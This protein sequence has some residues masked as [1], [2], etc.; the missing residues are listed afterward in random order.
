M[1]DPLF[2]SIAALGAAYRNRTLSPV[3][4]TRQA[5]E[6]IA[7]LDAR[8]NSFITVLE[9]R[10]LE[11][12][13]AAEHELAAGRDR[14]PLHGVPIAIKDLMD[15]AGVPTTFAS[16][17]GSPKLPGADAPVIQ[18]LEEAG[19][20]I[21]GKTNLLEYAYGAVHPDF[22]QTNNPWDLNRTSGGSSGGSAAAVATGFCFAALGTDT[23]G[24]IRIPASYCGVV[25]LKPTFNLVELVGVQPLSWSL[26]HVGPIARSC[27]DAALMLQGMT[28]QRFPVAA[29]KLKGLRLGVMQHDGAERFLEPEVS[30]CF[31]AVLDR[32]RAAG[33]S[34]EPVSVEGMNG[35][36][37][38]L[39]AL[40][41]PEASL[42]HERLIKIEPEEFGPITRQQIEAG[43][44][45]P[46]VA[47]LR[48][49]AAQ[50][51]LKARFA[52]LFARVDAVLSPAVPWVA[53]AEDPALE[54]EG[55]AGEMLY[56]AVYNLTGLPALVLPMGIGAAQ[57]PVAL[58]LVM[59]S[60]RDA[61]LLSLGAAVEVG[62]APLGM[63]TLVSGL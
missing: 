54:G 48:A 53:P 59:A 5:L 4:V 36:A 20:V 42:I 61:Q 15:M 52:A 37:E 2:L 47:Y 14:G 46:A 62:I 26:D 38:A 25:G 11:R 43:F 7:R 28:G 8:L 60:G 9:A 57:M 45:V 49:Q 39:L 24:S 10:S 34:V 22:G 40:I 50:K 13:E 3:A 32:L 31:A 29:A 27:A 63:P 30:A 58:Q 21:L 41:E 12:A 55:G 6:R 33:A 1:T 35:A 18:R 51:A 16:R 17:A 23:G 19:A 56:S 44:S